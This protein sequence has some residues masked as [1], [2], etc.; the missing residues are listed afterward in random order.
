VDVARTICFLAD[1]RNGWITGA[2][3]KIDGGVHLV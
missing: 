2:E 3:I 1:P